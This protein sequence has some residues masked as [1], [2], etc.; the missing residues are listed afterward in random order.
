MIVAEKKKEA[1][2]EEMAAL[3][4]LGNAY[5]MTPVELAQ[6]LEAQKLKRL[7]DMEYLLSLEE[8]VLEMPEGDYTIQVRGPST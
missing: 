8:E 7:E 3:A 2:D 1:E 4:K 6:Y 5:E